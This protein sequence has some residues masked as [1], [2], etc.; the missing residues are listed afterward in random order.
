MRSENI[1]AT[2][3]ATLMIGS[4]NNKSSNVGSLWTQESLK[5]V[6]GMHTFLNVG[7]FGASKLELVQYSWQVEGF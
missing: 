6:P 4:M 2:A 7:T 3:T 1:T 5:M